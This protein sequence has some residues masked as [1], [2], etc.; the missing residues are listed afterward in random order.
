M[1]QEHLMTALEILAKFPEDVQAPMQR[2]TEEAK[3][4]ALLG[5]VRKPYD[6]TMLALFEHILLARLLVRMQHQLVQDLE[7]EGVLLEEDAHK[8]VSRVI[9]PTEKALFEFTPTAAQLTRAGSTCVDN[10]VQS[11]LKRWLMRLVRKLEF[12]DTQ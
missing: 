2:I 11:H 8:L 1:T 12:H 3:K 5:L 9:K 10:Y 4:Q 6:S 7:K